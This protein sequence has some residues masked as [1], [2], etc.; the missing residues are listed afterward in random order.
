MMRAERVAIEEHT[1][2]RIL[3]NTM[4][5]AFRQTRAASPRQL[6]TDH[7]YAVSTREYQSDQPS[8]KLLDRLLALSSSGGNLCRRQRKTACNPRLSLLRP[9]SQNGPRRQGCASP[10]HHRAPLT[11]PGRSKNLPSLRR[12]AQSGKPKPT[13]CGLAL[14][15]VTP[16]Q[17]CI[18]S[19]HS[20]T[21][22]LVRDALARFR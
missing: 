17:C 10:R 14:D 6:P 11:A 1:G 20:R 22:A 19:A 4:R 8:Q 7:D 5:P 9:G 3:E 18:G 21:S 13:S 2:R 12:K 15:R 16:Y